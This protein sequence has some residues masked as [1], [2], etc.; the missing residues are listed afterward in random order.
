MSSFRHR[1]PPYRAAHLSIDLSEDPNRDESIEYSL[2]IAHRVA[3][4][5]RYELEGGS[6]VDSNC[7]Y[8]MSRLR[9]GCS[10]CSHAVYKYA[11]KFFVYVSKNIYIH[12]NECTTAPVHMQY[13]I[14]L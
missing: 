14:L 2:K 7:I 11:V 9:E 6:S 3:E 1:H 13:S 5:S 10:W 8:C 4:A 12:V